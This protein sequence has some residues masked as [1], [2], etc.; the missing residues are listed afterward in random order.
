LGD[1]KVALVLDT[2][3]IIEFYSKWK[4]EYYVRE[5]INK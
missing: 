1:G 3:K 4:V 5:R 2:N